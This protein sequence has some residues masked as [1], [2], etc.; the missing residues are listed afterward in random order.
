MGHRDRAIEADGYV[1]DEPHRNN[2]GQWVIF[3][4]RY[5]DQPDEEN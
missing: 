4:R 5:D 2:A 3:G 1:V